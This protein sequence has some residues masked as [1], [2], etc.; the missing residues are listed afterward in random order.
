MNSSIKTKRITI[1]TMNCTVHSLNRMKRT[2]IDEF[3]EGRD[4][5]VE[6]CDG[7]RKLHEA[8]YWREAPHLQGQL[9]KTWLSAVERLSH[10]TDYI[11]VSLTF[12]PPIYVPFK[13]LNE[14]LRT[15]DIP[16][17]YTDTW[18]MNPPWLEELKKI[19]NEFQSMK[20]FIHCLQGKTM[21]GTLRKYPELA[22]YITSPVIRELF[23]YDIRTLALRG[24]IPP[25]TNEK[26]VE[27]LPDDIRPVLE[28]IAIARLG[29][30]T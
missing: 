29:E 13:M 22:E 19:E 7:L 14:M 26:L 30:N 16:T 27:K 28:K 20:R 23:D 21:Y 12:S 4:V 18:G 10:N 24:E 6:G 5:V 11:N 9:P 15:N 1:G 3:K 8:H 17:E 25:H 2:F